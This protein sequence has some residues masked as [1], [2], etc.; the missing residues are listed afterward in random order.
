MDGDKVCVGLQ[1]KVI[2]KLCGWWASCLEVPGLIKDGVVARFYDAGRQV[3]VDDVLCRSSVPKEVPCEI[4]AVK[5]APSDA[6]LF[7]ANAR[8]ERFKVLYIWFSAA[9]SFIRCPV[10]GGVYEM[11][12]KEN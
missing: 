8:A 6:R 9:P 11:V 2:E 12:L 1:A 7:D 3:E 4:V 5:F 10:G